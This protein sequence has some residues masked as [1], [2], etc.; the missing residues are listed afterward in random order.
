MDEDELLYGSRLLAAR[1][2]PR[3]KPPRREPKILTIVRLHVLQCMDDHVIQRTL[4]WRLK[5][6][7][8]MVGKCLSALVRENILSPLHPLAAEPGDVIKYGNIKLEW[9]EGLWVIQGPWGIPRIPKP[10]YRDD[11]TTPTKREAAKHRRKH[12]LPVSDWDGRVHS[13]IRGKEFTKAAAKA[14]LPVDPTADWKCPQCGRNNKIYALCC[15]SGQCNYERPH[16]LYRP[17]TTSKP[18][19]ACRRCGKHHLRRERALCNAY[20]VQEV[21][22]K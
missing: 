13:I 4:S 11:R 18:T 19:K 21:M 17:V 12:P 7:E 5:T 9:H 15:H 2:R 14:G 3:R 10:G 1:P 8:H 16:H 22:E 6:P 20:I